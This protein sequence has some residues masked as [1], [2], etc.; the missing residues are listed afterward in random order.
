MRATLAVV[1]AVVALVSATAQVP[2]EYGAILER[3]RAADMQLAGCPGDDPDCPAGNQERLVCLN[4]S[5]YLVVAEARPPDPLFV[6]LVYPAGAGTQ[7]VGNPSAFVTAQPDQ[8]TGWGWDSFKVDNP[9]CYRISAGGSGRV[10]VYE[11]LL[12][13]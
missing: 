4:K 6:V 11:L 12:G 3:V 13:H 1:I 8:D 2:D 7:G 9:D 5:L 10:I